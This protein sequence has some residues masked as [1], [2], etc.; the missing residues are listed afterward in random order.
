MNTNDL[1]LFVRIADCESIARAAQ[2]L[3]ITS[4]AASAALKRLE[5]ELTVQLFIRSTRQLRITAEGERFLLH[6]RQALYTLEEGKASINALHGKVSGELRISA[7]SDLS[8]NILID[9]M[10]EIMDQYPALSIHLVVSDSMADFYHDRVDIAL[11]YGLPEDSSL[12]AFKLAAFERIL[13]ASPRYLSSFGVPS[14]PEDLK[15]HN[16]LIYQLKN[17]L[18]DIWSFESKVIG[19]NDSFKIKVSSNRSCNDGDVVRRWV[20]AGKG[21][22]Y[23]SR[24]DIAEDLQAGRVIRLLSNFRTPLLELNLIC[25][26]RKQVTPAVLL[27]RDTLRKKLN[28][29][30]SN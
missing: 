27:L 2:Q 23:K 4:A 28:M 14:H 3:D 11:R 29:L 6:C 5:K 1:T 20:V 25:P 13:C 26:T 18:F 9:C 19:K 30:L 10:D 16:C 15:Q 8:R 21:I 12:I 24:L 17:R 22:A 7:P